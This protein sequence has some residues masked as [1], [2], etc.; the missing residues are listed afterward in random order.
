MARSDV[1]SRVLTAGR[2]V[3]IRVGYKA[4]IVENILREA[5]IARGTFYKYFKDKRQVMF[6]IMS[7]ISRTL[8]EGIGNLMREQPADRQTV[9]DHMRN[10]L[11]LAHRFFLENQE[12]L[13]VYQREAYGLDPMLSAVWDDFERRMNSVFSGFLSRG[14]DKGIFRGMDTGL[15][16]RALTTLLLEVPFQAIVTGGRTDIDVESIA[17]E[18]VALVF[19]GILAQ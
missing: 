19:R 3:F 6:E 2:L 18:M 15:A 9:S 11:V 16:A 1:R 13:V 7:T 4:A 8:L 5:G 10:A 14:I 12:I 17:E